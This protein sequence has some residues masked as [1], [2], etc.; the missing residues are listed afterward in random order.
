MRGSELRGGRGWHRVARCSVGAGHVTQSSMRQWECQ[1]DGQLRKVSDEARGASKALF[2]QQVGERDVNCSNCRGR[3]EVSQADTANRLDDLRRSMPTEVR[4]SLQRSLQRCLHRSLP[5]YRD[6]YRHTYKG[7][8]I[9]TLENLAID[10]GCRG[11]LL[12]RAVRE[13]I[14]C[15]SWCTCITRVRIEYR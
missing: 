3:G 2:T 8:S 6:A 15:V 7:V 11:N 1:R 14:A 9:E 5:A 13:K 10:R 4:T 12:L